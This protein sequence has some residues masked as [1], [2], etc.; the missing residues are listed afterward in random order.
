MK[1][2]TPSKKMIMV[3]CLSCGAMILVGIII[4]LVWSKIDNIQALYFA[5]GVI[6]SSALNVGKVAMLERAVQKTLDME[7]PTAGG[8]F[9]RVQYLLRYFLT[10]LVLVAAGLVTKYVDPP[11]INIIGAIAGIFTMQ[12]AVVTVRSMKLE[13]T[14]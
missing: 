4:C 8:N 5:I 6:L 7:N 13:E 12:I 10:G 3:I 1:M 11:F 14:T 2:S 9:I